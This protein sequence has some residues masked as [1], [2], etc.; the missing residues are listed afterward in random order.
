M[1]MVQAGKYVPTLMWVVYDDGNDK[2]L[3]AFETEEEAEAV[4]KIYDDQ[5]INVCKVPVMHLTTTWVPVF[6]DKEDKEVE[7]G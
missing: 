5:W 3:C 4:A 1:V 6:G 7:N 2:A